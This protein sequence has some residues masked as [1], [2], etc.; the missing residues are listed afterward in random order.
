MDKAAEL[1][2]HQVASHL[3]SQTWYW[4]VLAAILWIG[5][6]AVAA[7]FGS[8]IKTKAEID[9]KDENMQSILDQLDQT[10]SL[11]RSIEKRINQEDWIERE[12]KTL[13]RQKIEEL[14]LSV[15]ATIRWVDARSTAVFGRKRNVELPPRESEKTTM[16][17]SLY[18]QELSQLV[19]EFR[20]LE[21]SL[22]QLMTEAD[23]GYDDETMP[24]DNFVEQLERRHDEFSTLYTKFYAK[25]H[26]I[27][28]AAATVMQP[29]ITPPKVL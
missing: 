18:V 13:K 6:S 9:A 22:A 29:I 5:V 7:Y 3:I 19:G 1:F 25:S 23:V 11:S 14:V 17:A 8:H 27:T 2:A 21:T 10:V 26:E 28:E 16:L 4:W 24:L 12:A 15:F 20:L